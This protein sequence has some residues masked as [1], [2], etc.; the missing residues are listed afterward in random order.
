M[1][2]R[3]V[4]STPSAPSYAATDGAAY[5]RFLGRWSRRV[6]QRG[7]VVAAAV[8]D[9]R[10]GLVFQRLFWATAAG[11]DPSAGVVR[12]R[13]FSGPLALPDG[14]PMLWRDSGLTAVERGS[15]TIRME[16]AD[17]AD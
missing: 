17:F 10:G 5:E 2:Q 14:L 13:L 11:L 12:D 15:I 3:S 8:W 1:S 9:F 16:Y 7:G 4:T 6:V